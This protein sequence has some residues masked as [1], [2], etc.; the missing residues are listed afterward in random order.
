MRDCAYLHYHASNQ[1]LRL[2]TRMPYMS[3]DLDGQASSR[4]RASAFVLFCWFSFFTFNT[5]SIFSFYAQGAGFRIHFVS[6]PWFSF[7]TFNTSSIFSFYA[8]GAGFR[9]HFVSRPWFSFF[10]SVLSFYVHV[11]VSSSLHR[12]R[13]RDRRPIHPLTY[14]AEPGT[15]ETSHLISSASGASLLRYIAIIHPAVRSLLSDQP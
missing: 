13:H 5:S 4:G 11:L 6:R 14:K 7:F 2:K 1:T 12:H 10:T 15:R 8:Q 3:V 9:I